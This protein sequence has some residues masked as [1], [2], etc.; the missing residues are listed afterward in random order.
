MGGASGVVQGGMI[1]R[2]GRLQAKL[3]QGLE[4]VYLLLYRTFSKQINLICVSII[5]GLVFRK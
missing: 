3:G 1:V 5:T 4:R 2:G